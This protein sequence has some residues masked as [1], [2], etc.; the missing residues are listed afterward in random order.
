[1]MIQQRFA[2]SQANQSNPS[3]V[4][5][6]V[7]RQSSVKIVG[8]LLFLAVCVAVFVL[9]SH[10]SASTAH[11]TSTLHQ[12]SP[13]QLTITQHTATSP[14]SQTSSQP[15]SGQSSAAPLSSSSVSDTTSSSGSS[16]GPSKT[17]VSVNGQDIPVPQNGT[18]QKTISGTD[19]STS[20]SVS[21]SSQSSGDSSNNSSSSTE[22]NVSSQSWSDTSGSN[23][24]TAT[25]GVP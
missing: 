14:Q 24:T 20:V 11:N 5:S 10:T 13:T 4:L 3:S 21:S 7:L 1:M 6:H 19:G 15:Q 9:T 22:L 8:L 17:R 16:S 25:N 23:T 18:V 12:P 2:S